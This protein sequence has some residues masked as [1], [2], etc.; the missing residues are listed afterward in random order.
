M[1]RGLT[2]VVGVWLYGSMCLASTTQQTA[3]DD[4][5]ASVEA[6]PAVA[7]AAEPAQEPAEGP[8]TDGPAAEAAPPPVLAPR[9]YKQVVGHEAVHTVAAGET[10]GAIA[11]RYGTGVQVAA[12][13]N[14]IG[15]P[16]RLKLGQ[17]LTLS[18]RRILPTAVDDGLVV[19]LSVLR[20][21]WLQE[22]EIAATFQ[23]AAGRKTW[24]T[25]AGQYSITGRRRDPTWHVPP[26][27]QREM[28]EQG[29][30]VKT[31]VLPGPENP[32]GKYWLQL[33]GGGIGIHGTNAP[34]SVGKYAT[35]GCIRM[36]EADIERL[37]NEVPNGTT[38]TIIDDTV[39]VARLNDGRVFVEAHRNG[40]P[41]SRE[42]LA[43]RF[44][45]AGI[46]GEDELHRAEQIVRNAWGVAVEVTAKPSPQEQ[47]LR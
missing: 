46:T 34:W 37:F 23:V 12:A 7:P 4:A 42:T 36:R 14:S 22:G 11:K 8:A 26:S 9:L 16:T 30:P 31:K 41:I 15:D 25:P 43:L 24:E 47:A 5:T 28:K 33:S 2:A 6:P 27:I 3:A 1:R 32:L 18:N 13:M 44:E 40:R 35:H 20:M 38:V 21:Y 39:R 19:D 29:V 10:L 17:K 45:A